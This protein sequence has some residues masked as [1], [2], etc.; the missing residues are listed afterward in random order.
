MNKVLVIED[1][2]ATSELLSLAISQ[3]LNLQTNILTSDTANITKIS[4]NNYDLVILN[5]YYRNTSC[6]DFIDTI[7]K[8]RN[9]VPIIVISEFEHLHIENFLIDSGAS[10]VINKPFALK[11]IIDSVVSLLLKQNVLS[12]NEI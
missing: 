5:S 7:K 12:A 9:G 6:Y 10:I 4:E 8:N 2:H 1:D 3:I 11:R